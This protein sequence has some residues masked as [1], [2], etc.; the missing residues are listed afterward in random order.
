VEVEGAEVTEKEDVEGA[1]EKV[2]GDGVHASN[3]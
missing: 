2:E 3:V 1:E